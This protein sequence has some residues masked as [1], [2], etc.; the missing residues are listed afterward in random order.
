MLRKSPGFFCPGLFFRFQRIREPMMPLFVP[1]TVLRLFYVF[2][3]TGNIA[4]NLNRSRCMK[5]SLL[6]MDHL[7]KIGSC[8][9]PASTFA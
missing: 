9:R 2:F 1:V 6:K 3:L 4:P 5:E 8:A 7:S